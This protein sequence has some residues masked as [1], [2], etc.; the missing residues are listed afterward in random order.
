MLSRSCW[1]NLL[2]TTER[3]TRI[4]PTPAKQTST[5]TADNRARAWSLSWWWWWWWW[6]WWRRWWP[7]DDGDDANTWRWRWW[8]DNDQPFFWCFRECSFYPKRHLIIPVLVL[9]WRGEVGQQSPLLPTQ[10]LRLSSSW[11]RWWCWFWL[12]S[13]PQHTH[14]RA[15]KKEKLTFESQETSENLKLTGWTK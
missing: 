11:S 5:T 13:T 4:F 12:R 10:F 15:Q 6:S 9:L 1:S 8:Y 14:M 3:M 2:R 7:D